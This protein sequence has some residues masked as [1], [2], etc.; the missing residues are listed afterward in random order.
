MPAALALVLAVLIMKDEGL[1]AC[2]NVAVPDEPIVSL[3]VAEP[4]LCVTQC[5]WPSVS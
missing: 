1:A 2:A 5:V 4:H 3:C